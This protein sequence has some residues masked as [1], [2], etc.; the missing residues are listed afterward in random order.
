M[1]PQDKTF[2]QGNDLRSL[3]F[4]GSTTYYCFDL[5]SATDRFPMFLILGLMESILGSERSIAWYNIMVGQAFD[6]RDPSGSSSLLKYEVGNP[7]GF[8]SS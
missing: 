6:Y 3:P 1:I 2:N 4:D 7:M 8:L 5:S